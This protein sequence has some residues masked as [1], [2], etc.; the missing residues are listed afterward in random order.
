MNYHRSPEQMLQLITGLGSA[1]EPGSN[2]DYSNSNYFLLS[3]ILE[4]VYQQPYEDILLSKIIKPLNLQ[5]TQNGEKISN[6]TSYSFID[7]WEKLNET[8]LSI[9][10]GSGSIVSTPQDVA[11]FL[12]A[13]FT[14]KIISEGSL[15]K[16]QMIKNTYG[17][18]LMRFNLTDR[19]GFGHR[20]R[21]DGFKSTSIFFPN[22]NLGLVLTSNA[23]RNNINEIYLEILKL[24]F[25]DESLVALES[26]V[27][28][29]AGVYVSITDQSDQFV[30]KQDGNKLI[31]RVQNEF[32][33]PLVFKGDNRFIFEQVYA[34]SFAFKFSDE[35]KTVNVTQGGY[36]GTFKKE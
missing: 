20:G 18:G 21:I 15:E 31:L 32:D 3:Q 33:E 8:D 19:V 2:A 1:F 30:F 25:D 7:S 6:N 12:D 23:S 36:Q 26:E 4:K 22:E 35:G 16:M 27:K 11:M 9:A 13:L 5:N 34:E 24:Y 10:I 29:F 17:M 14:G 28:K